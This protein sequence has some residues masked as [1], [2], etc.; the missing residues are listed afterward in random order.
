MTIITVNLSYLMI[1]RQTL[2]DLW[3]LS[4]RNYSKEMK[5]WNQNMTYL[6][7]Y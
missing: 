7:I 5:V 2:V 3:K 6:G 4:D 1:A